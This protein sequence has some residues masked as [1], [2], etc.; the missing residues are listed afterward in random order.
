MS[1]FDDINKSFGIKA[2]DIGK[3]LKFLKSMDETYFSV[4]KLPSEVD[5][6]EKLPDDFSKSNVY[7]EVDV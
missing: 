1:L 3:G 6:N 7:M 5:E 2:E 4:L